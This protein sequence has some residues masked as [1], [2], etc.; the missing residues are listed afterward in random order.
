[1][2]ARVYET[3][4]NYLLQIEHFGMFGV[5]WVVHSGCIPFCSLLDLPIYEYMPYTALRSYSSIQYRYLI[6]ML[7]DDLGGG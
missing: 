1:M 5:I 3:A 4:S 6:E 2:G 7:S